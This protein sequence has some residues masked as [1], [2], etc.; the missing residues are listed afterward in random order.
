MTLT[1][2]GLSINGPNAS[3]LPT[4]VLDVLGTSGTTLRIRDGNQ[5]IGSVLTCTTA[6][7][8]G[9]L[10]SWQPAGA[11]SAIVSPL[12]TSTAAV[13]D[14]GVFTVSNTTSGQTFVS[15]PILTTVQQ[16]TSTVNVD[17]GG[18]TVTAAGVANLFKVRGSGLVL[19]VTGTNAAA[20]VFGELQILKNGP[21]ASTVTSAGGLSSF[22]LARTDGT[23][24]ARLPVASGEVIG[25]LLA[26]SFDGSTYGI[27]TSITFVAAENQAV[28]AHGAYMSFNA[29]DLGNTIVTARMIMTSTGLAVNGLSGSFFPTATLDVLGPSGAAFRLRDGNQAAAKQLVSI[30]GNGVAQWQ[31][32]SIG[33]LF[34]TAGVGGNQAYFVAVAT[35]IALVPPVP[36]TLGASQDFDQPAGT[37]G[38]LRYIG[39]LAKNFVVTMT[40]SIAGSLVADDVYLLVYKNGAPLSGMSTRATSAAGGFQQLAVTVSVQLVTNDFLEIWG[41]NQ[42]SPNFA[43]AALSISATS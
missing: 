25:S 22:I 27:N 5:A 13:T 18:V 12:G 9:G 36:A 3:F 23:F 33:A 6:G 21:I 11:P 24:A 16:G 28:G 8:N 7:A 29:V 30:D 17:S 38:R 2:T 20:Q 42:T 41:M 26:R 14:N 39:L 43:L 35:P 1:S 31:F 32:P 34:W 40:A 37:P 19:D 15:T 4:T 10:A